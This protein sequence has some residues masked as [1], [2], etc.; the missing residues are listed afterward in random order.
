MFCFFCCSEKGKVLCRYLRY[1]MLK[2]RHFSHNFILIAVRK[3]IFS[4]SMLQLFL[5][6][7]NGSFTAKCL[8][9]SFQKKI[10][11]KML[12]LF[13]KFLLDFI[14]LYL[15][16]CVLA[17]VFVHF[18]FSFFVYIQLLFTT[19]YVIFTFST[20][21]FLITST[22]CFCFPNSPFERDLPH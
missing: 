18:Y 7:K 17:N 1:E 15:C 5:E 20:L 4:F 21:F 12:V 16:V 2:R 13:K 19:I 14:Y 3:R 6:K 10:S 9:K 8:H 11:S 22:L